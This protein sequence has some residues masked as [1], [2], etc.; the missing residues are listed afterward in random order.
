MKYF[1][2]AG[3]ALF[4]C[5]GALA[6]GRAVPTPTVQGTGSPISSPVESEV[7]RQFKQ[8]DLVRLRS[9]GPAMTV[10]AVKGDQVVCVWTDYTGQAGDGTF[11]AVVL[12]KL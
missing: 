11:P 7:S 8:G 12:Q 5:G 9:G 10:S 4:A 3:L 1:L 2:A 6:Q